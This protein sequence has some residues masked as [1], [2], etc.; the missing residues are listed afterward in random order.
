MAALLIDRA[1][2]RSI[3]SS[4][5]GFSGYRLD[6]GQKVSRG[7][8]RTV[9]FETVAQTGLRLNGGLPARET[10]GASAGHHRVFVR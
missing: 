10:A 8:V 1:D 3:F 7:A 4:L 6:R 9:G 2:S 5:T